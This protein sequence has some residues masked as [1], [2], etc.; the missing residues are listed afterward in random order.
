MKNDRLPWRY[1]NGE[2]VTGDEVGLPDS[3]QGLHYGTGA[4][5]GIRAYRTTAGSVRPFRAVEHFGR[6]VRSAG[7]LRISLQESVD[8]L[9]AVCDDLLKRNEVTEDCYI[10]PIVFKQALLPSTPYGI[11]LT[12]VTH[13]LVISLVPMP[14]RLAEGRSVRLHLTDIRRIPASSIPAG[15]KVTGAYVNNAL[16]VQDAI[17]NGYDDA[18][19]LTGDG[20][21]AEAS[22]SN[23]FCVRGSEVATPDVT[24]DI[25]PGIT[26]QV[27]LDI[28]GR[29][30]GL[31]VHERKIGVAELLESDEVFLTG[32]GIEVAR[33]ASIGRT[34]IGSG[35]AGHSIT[36]QLAAEYAR[37]VRQSS[38]D[39]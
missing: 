3:T 32:T 29:M 12:G 37:Q 5:E 19:M 7:I 23:V 1:H 4:Y 38:P 26:R 10:R 34:E 28:L 21:V 14:S 20:Y 8:D 33:V 9:V 36:S 11:R 31:T 22:T 13:S 25:L 16:A 18:L 17:E 2:F 30:P 39:R 35:P 6:L 24:S 27:S 15:A